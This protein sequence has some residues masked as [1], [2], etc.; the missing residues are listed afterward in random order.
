[1]LRR[2]ARFLQLEPEE[3]AQ[4]LTLG[5]ILFA[6]TGSYTLVKTARDTLFLAR[7]PVALLP[8]VFLG[9]GALTTLAA[10]LHARVTRDR[11]TWRSLED[12]VWASAISLAGFAFL[13]RFEGRWVPIAFYLW[14]NV[15]GLILMAQFWSFLNS[16]SHPR[17]A[18][19]TFGLIG[20]GG[21]LGGL[22]GGMLAPALVAMFGL[23]AL[24]TAGAVV[25]AAA[26]PVV[27]AGVRS[28]ELPPPEAGRDAAG[29]AAAPLSHGYVRWLALAALC[30]VLVTTLL[31]YQF[32][33]ELQRRDLTPQGLA[34]FLGLFYTATNLAAL[35]MQVFV[36]R[37]ALQRL[38][39]GW[40][41]AVLPGGLAL[42]AAAT[43]LVPGFAA[44]MTT[45]LWDQVMRLS[46][47]RSAVE[48][49]FFPLTPGMRRKAKALIEAGLERIGDALA[50]ILLL[51]VGA[52]LGAGTA[53]L[54]AIV[55]GLVIVWV[56][57]WLRVRRLYVSELGRNLRRMSLDPGNAPV[58]LRESSILLETERLLG[59]GQEMLVL[60]G[61]E[62]MAEN[63]PDRLAGHLPALAR[64]PAAR[65]RAR[66]LRA[67]S[68]RAAGESAGQVEELMRD[69]DPEVRIEAMRARF[70]LGG[71]SPLGALE[72]FLGA[73]DPALRRSAFLAIA[74]YADPGDEP[75]VRGW[76]ER[77][78]AAGA[79]ERATVA[80]A[81]GRRGAEGAGPELL[82]ELVRDPSPEVR[83][84]ALRSAGRLRR[85]TLTPALLEA[86][87]DPH[88]RAAARDGLLAF[89]VH[90][91]GTLGDY[92]S[93][94][95]VALAIRREIPRVLRDIGG[96][97][98]VAALFRA[99]ERRD[100]RLDYRV[101][102]AL[103]HIR[104]RDPGAAFPAPLVRDDLEHDVRSHVFALV[105]YRA[106]PIGG[107]RTAERLLCIALN[108][109]MDQALNRIFRRL[110]LLYPPD[111]IFAAWRGVLSEDPRLRGNALEYLENALVPED[112]VRV[113]PLVDDSGDEGRLRFAE[114]RYGMRFLGFSESLDQI[115]QGDDP[116]LRTCALYVAG[117]R[118][119]RALL[120]R[121]EQLLVS[122]EPHVQETASWAHALLARGAT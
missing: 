41:A 96:P 60:Q 76:L 73:E 1:M 109:R 58:S 30:S 27:R 65:V 72:E 59:S 91:A 9:V 80:E 14:V 5:A 53:T 92:L 89:G 10:A 77:W 85:R 12:A 88:G 28:G 114:S 94:G 55:L 2:V 98:A 84:A 63:D 51:V 21:I 3:A 90:V 104:S 43:L 115:L 23:P 83:G 87:A 49:F 35:T 82:A 54:A 33:A 66:A 64:H 47:N 29:A 57:A 11:A 52:T 13:F 108:E 38:G 56:V 39:A 117:S 16:I 93:D 74:E 97:E 7:L 95:G 111:D 50:G 62:M 37:W 32:K 102:K 70:A 44:V 46:I 86:L 71:G 61:I 68:E 25:V 6:L 119:E 106:C 22:A 118:G 78:L 110:A 17:Q 42:G 99:R 112:G 19:R 8:W 100:V 48:L 20:T 116:W 122:R 69:P 15:Y 103:N 36:T 4:A 75:R 121:V 120:P 31:D 101:L 34:S 45:R 81:I 79:F 18:K 107:H 113:L 105:H 26:A 67:M 40:S 24:L